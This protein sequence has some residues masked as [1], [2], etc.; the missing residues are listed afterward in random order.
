MQNTDLKVS[1]AESVS[2]ATYGKRSGKKG[3]EVGVD[4]DPGNPASQTA[5]RPVNWWLISITKLERE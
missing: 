2:V 1:D 4:I 5:A 3:R